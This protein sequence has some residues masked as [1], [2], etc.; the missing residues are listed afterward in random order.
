MKLT[1]RIV[2]SVPL[3][4]LAVF[5]IRA[6]FYGSVMSAFTAK[7]G[8]SPI[9]APVFVGLS[10]VTPIVCIW[11]PARSALI[12]GSVV[13]VPVMLYGCVLLVI[14]VLGIAIL[15]AVATWVVCARIAWNERKSST[16]RP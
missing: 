7:G 16:P 12:A 4:I 11:I 1:P 2:G 9:L 14:P 8:G 13:L 10:L 3:G 5:A 6:V 15:F